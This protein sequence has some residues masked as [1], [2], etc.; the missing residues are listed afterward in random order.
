MLSSKQQTFS[1]TIIENYKLI[2]TINLNLYLT[3]DFMITSSH[4]KRQD[5]IFKKF[6]DFTQKGGDILISRYHTTYTLK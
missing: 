6:L 2:N 1:F 4:G 3:N 5:I